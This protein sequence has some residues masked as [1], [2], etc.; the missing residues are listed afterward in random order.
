VED[1]VEMAV[2]IVAGCAN[3]ALGNVIGAGL[4]FVR[5][6][7]GVEAHLGKDLA[8]ILHNGFN[9]AGKD[10]AKLI[11]KTLLRETKGSAAAR[12]PDPS[13]LS[14]KTLYLQAAQQETTERVN[15]IVDG[16]TQHVATLK[17]VPVD[18]LLALSERLNAQ[19]ADNLAKEIETAVVNEWVNF[20][21]AA[22]EK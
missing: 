4:R 1:L 20:G 14:P 21:K 13:G 19:A 2:N 17:R 3:A 9:T 15:Q 6:Q 22:A 16:F 5:A 18:T 10:N 11:G 7:T 12:Q 8:D